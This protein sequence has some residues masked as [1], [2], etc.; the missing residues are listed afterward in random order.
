MKQHG[1]SW[2]RLV[3]AVVL[4]GNAAA[5]A[6]AFVDQATSWGVSM[7]AV[8]GT[9]NLGRGAAIADFNGDGLV[10]V[11]IPGAPGTPYMPFLNLGPG[12][13][14]V[15]IVAT[16]MGTCSH[17]K[18]MVVGDFD[19]D[20]YLDIYVSNQGT[21]N[22]LFRGV[23]PM[24]FVDVAPQAGVAISGDSFQAL[25]LDYDRDGYLDL[26]SCTRPMPEAAANNHLFHNNHDGTFTDV[27]TESGTAHGSLTFAATSFDYD[28]DGWPDILS[29]ADNAFVPTYLPN[30]VFRNNHDGTFTDVAPALGMDRH[31]QAMGVD[32]ADVNNDGRMAVIISNTNIAMGN[33]MGNP[34]TDGHAMFLWNPSTQVFDSV[35]IPYGTRQTEIGWACFYID[36]DNDG[37]QDAFFKHMGGPC[38]LMKNTPT[39]PW[40]NMGPACGFTYAGPDVSAG[41]GD[42]NNDGC[43]DILE[44]ELWRA[45]CMMI[46]PGFN[47]NHWL[48]I[49]LVGTVSNRLG[50][51]AR[52]RVTTTA[53]G[54]T[55]T[56]WMKSGQG[57][58]V[59]C[60][61]IVHFGLGTNTLI[62]SLE[63]T[64][65]SGVVQ[66]LTNVSV[67]QSLTITEP[68]MVMGGQEATGNFP[69]TLS[70]PSEPTA[71]YVI[72]LSTA[73]SPGI[74][75]GDGRT[76]PLAFDWLLDFCLSP[77]NTLGSNQPFGVLDGAGQR[78]GAFWFPTGLTGFTCHSA[79]VTFNA[80][81]PSGVASIIGPRTIV[82][83]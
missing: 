72:A 50:I 28:S 22:Q 16:G 1:S 75:L 82:L 60:E 38:G 57:F 79:A 8:V 77:A 14:F 40:V 37:R 67:D 81:A 18:S 39:L 58:L 23:G 53:D 31:M 34:T 5:V 42:F 4:V 73:T 33:M 56:N 35:E 7:P 70:V 41:F 54:T 12:I 59:S 68:S 25:W 78:M 63:V 10:D 44:P 47:A 21:P 26:Y 27:T 66:T 65:P 62:N 13:G 2:L 32:F 24:A 29:T 51:G 64:W 6:Q 69:W 9:T 20:G 46:N 36:Y 80:T 48:K 61:P 3:A 30:K 19:N 55:R 45:S 74:P 49:H 83:P 76:V 71:S 17:A 15:P 52:V 43:L 11:I